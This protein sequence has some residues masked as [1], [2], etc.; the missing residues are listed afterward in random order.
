MKIGIMTFHWANNYG[1]SLQ[2]YA[3]KKVILD[4]GHS[5]EIID[6]KNENL[7]DRNQALSFKGKTFRQKIGTLLHYPYYKRKI[8][9]FEAF[10]NKYLKPMKYED[11]NLVENEYD[12]IIVGSDQVWNYKITNHDPRYFLDF[13]NDNSKKCSYAASFGLPN[14]PDSMRDSYKQFLTSFDTLLVRESSG[15]KLVNELTGREAEQVLDPTLLLNKADWEKTFVSS[16]KNKKY[17]LL[18]LFQTDKRSFDFA[19]YLANKTGYEIYVLGNTRRKAIDAKYF[20]AA[21]PEQWV[22][23]F[24]NAEIIITNSFHGTVFSINFKKKFFVAPFLKTDVHKNE[25]I[26]DILSAMKF[27]DR[28]I[29]YDN[30]EDIKI[31]INYSLAENKLAKMRNNSLSAL[32]NISILGKEGK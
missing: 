12:K 22:E 25:R 7:E 13:V 19:K 29:N 17:I 31:D 5:C 11:I 6:Y 21:S 28:Y 30:F 26:D 9:R 1:A 24:Y 27:T 2:A 18:Y 20:R 8:S 15:V 10:R 32:S 4:M 23:L 3:L 16:K 14:I